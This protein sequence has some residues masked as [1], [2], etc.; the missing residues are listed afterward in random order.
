[1]EFID[2][3]G[4]IFSLKSYDR[5]PI[6]YEYEEHPYIFWI[7]NKNKNK[8]SINNYYGRSIYI[9]Y[10]LDQEAYNSNEIDLN[11]RYKI[12]ISMDSS[13]YRLL[14]PNKIN[15]YIN[16]LSSLYDNFEIKGV[17][18]K[19]N[20]TSITNDDAILIKSYN[21]I[22]ANNINTNNKETYKEY[23]A[24]IPIYVLGYSKN[25]GTWMTNILININDTALNVDEWCYITY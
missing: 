16:N 19:N 14:P 25:E 21:E 6:G 10:K 15:N 13:V 18:L 20:Q 2:N 12:N 11:N 1:M 9:A 23:Y 8:L 17:D 24:I 3:S 22:E 5:K 7:D 4:H